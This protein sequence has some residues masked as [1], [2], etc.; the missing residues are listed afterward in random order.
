MTLTPGDLKRFSGHLFNLVER[1]CPNVNHSTLFELN[2]FIA[3]A[4]AKDSDPV[5]GDD[6]TFQEVINSIRICAM[7]SEPKPKTEETRVPDLLV[8]R[9][10]GLK[11]EKDGDQQDAQVICFCLHYK[12]MLMSSFVS[13]L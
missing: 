7:N 2:R 6:K 8:T 9:V 5:A 12:V 13:I 1:K 10:R 11:L 4:I 3:K